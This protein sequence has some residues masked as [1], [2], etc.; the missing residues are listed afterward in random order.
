[1]YRDG[2]LTRSGGDGG[3]DFVGRLDVGTTGSNTPL[4]VL[5]QA[6]CVSSK[7]S[8]GADQVARVVARLRRGWIGVYVTTGVF[9]RQA[10]IEIIDDQYPLVLVNGREL[11]EQVVQLAATDHGTD[12][13]ALLSRITDEYEG[14]VTHRRPEEI[15]FA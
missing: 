14:A 5:G 8:I 3:V 7:T 9:S 12:I 13:D 4:V 2:W 11:V 10:Q 1:M 6:K 15:L